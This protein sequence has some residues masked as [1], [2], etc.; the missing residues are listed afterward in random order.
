MA[1][2]YHAIGDVFGGS[3]L[4]AKLGEL[5]R[6]LED[7][8]V[9]ARLLTEE[10]ERQGMESAR[11]EAEKA[12]ALSAFDA[13]VPLRY[14]GARLSDFRG[15]AYR[16]AVEALSD[17]R[18]GVVLGGNGTG[19]TRMAWAV[20]RHAAERGVKGEY[21][22]A[23]RLMSMIADGWRTHDSSRVERCR[24]TGYLVVDEIDKGY[25]SQA[26]Y[27]ELTDLVSERY[28]WM[29]PTLLIGNSP[30]FQTFAG[31]VGSAVA[32]RMREDG[33]LAVLKGESLRRGIRLGREEANHD[34]R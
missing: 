15:G 22:T 7:P 26:E 17:L 27:L 21:V 23:R 4:Q 30:D 19:K 32:D 10:A 29:K 28:E 20:L 8:E 6:K 16:G 14:R 2:E 24:T 1:Q 25:G 5:R 11:L 13:T 12:Q 31:L 33:F 9:A 18:G 3:A 34:Q